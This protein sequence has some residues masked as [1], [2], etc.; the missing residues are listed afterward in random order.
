MPVL[1]FV[2]P[3]LNEEASIHLLV[4]EIEKAMTC[5]DGSWQVIFID[6]GS[7][8][9]SWKLICEA[10]EQYPQI[11]GIRLRRRFGK[12]A[13]LAAGFA[14]A[15]GDVI[16]TLDSDLQDDPAEVIPMLA[17]MKD[18]R[19]DLVSGW[20]KERHDP[21]HKVFPSRV[22]NWM[23]STI[24]G[25]KLHDHNC[26]LKVMKKQVGQEVILYGERHRFIPVLAA[27]R[28][29]KVGE[30]V[31]QHRP[32]QFGHSKYGM[33]RFL[34]GFLDLLTVRFL[35]SY[36][37]RPQHLLGIG[38]IL[39]AV[40]GVLGMI[41]LAIDWFQPGHTPLHQRPLL[42]YS[43][44]SLLLGVQLF[45]MGLLAE[46]ITSQRRRLDETYSIAERTD[47]K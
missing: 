14:Q 17:M 3:V 15:S 37:H 30:K 43:V 42:T 25:V 39:F 38:G 1:S 36:E 5:Y 12:A 31:V 24:T 8:D 13:A 9:Q 4:A 2:I 22:F 21:W 20:K 46:L 41:Y 34:K 27:A 32:R 19:L 16:A 40:L 18:Q 6:D 45:S 29:F 35:T 11:E 26:G 33:G 44:T 10:A 23:V 47:P 7:T 28:G